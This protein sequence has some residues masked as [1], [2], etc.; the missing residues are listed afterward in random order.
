MKRTTATPTTAAPMTSM[1]LRG[2]RIDHGA[3]SEPERSLANAR[4]WAVL[5][6]GSC[7]G[8]GMR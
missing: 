5:A 1:R 6:D 4:N 8:V 2:A 3:E 7:S